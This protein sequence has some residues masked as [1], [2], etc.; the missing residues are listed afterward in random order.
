M[1]ESISRRSG[2]PIGRRGAIIAGVVVVLLVALFGLVF[3]LLRQRLL[4]TEPGISL[5][6]SASAPPATWMIYRDPAGYFSIRVPPGWRASVETGQG[7]MGDRTGNFS[8]TEETIMLAAPADLTG[9][10]WVS[11][12]VQPLPNAFA[13]HF[14]CQNQQF[15]PVATSLDGLPAGYDNWTW[16]LNTEA[17]HFQ[18]STWLSPHT[19]LPNLP[20]P[21]PVRT[22]TIATDQRLLAQVI[23]SFQPI[24]AT[25]LSC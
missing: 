20:P 6:T 14:A 19:S 7:N 13:R 1:G 8:F 10:L 2:W 4:V 17:A 12:S 21:T 3:V 15:G 18:I 16:F 23:A 9:V 25:A 22:A 11:L 5:V 24:P